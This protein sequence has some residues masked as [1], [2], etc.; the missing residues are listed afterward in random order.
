ML[1]KIVIYQKISRQ[2]VKGGVTTVTFDGNSDKS[3]K[4][5]RF[6]FDYSEW[7]HYKEKGDLDSLTHFYFPFILI[8]KAKIHISKFQY[9]N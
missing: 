7:L 2:N 8:A 1:L 4:K 3:P 6:S 5:N 9:W